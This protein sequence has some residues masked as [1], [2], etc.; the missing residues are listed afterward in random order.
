MTSR[1][2]AQNEL[3]LSIFD[4]LSSSYDSVLDWMTLYQDRKWK[5]RM[6][7]RLELGESVVTKL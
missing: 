6:L 1:V 2:V 5:R 4:G 3:A 7:Q